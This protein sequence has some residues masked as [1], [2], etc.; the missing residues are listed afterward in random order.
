MGKMT[1]KGICVYVC[2]SH[3][4]KGEKKTHTEKARE[5]F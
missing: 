1:L 3:L 2:M 4:K 5:S